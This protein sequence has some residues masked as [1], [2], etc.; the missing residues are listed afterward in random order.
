MNPETRGYIAGIIDAAAA[1]SISKAGR[2]SIRITHKDIGLLR[3]VSET[4]RAGIIYDHG[5]NGTEA[6]GGYQREQ[7]QLYRVEIHR[8]TDILRILK[9]VSPVLYLKKPKAERIIRILS[10]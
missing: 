7:Q 2:P 5:E 1:L 6:R 10:K 3:H 8:Q 9:E 4:M